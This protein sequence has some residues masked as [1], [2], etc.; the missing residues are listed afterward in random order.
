MKNKSGMAV[1]LSLVILSLTG[2]D[3]T[4]LLNPPESALSSVTEQKPAMGFQLCGLGSKL[5]RNSVIKSRK[6]T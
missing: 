5:Q 1:V 2:I 3:C 6:P 4:A